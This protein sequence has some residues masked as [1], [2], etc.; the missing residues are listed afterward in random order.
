MLLCKVQRIQNILFQMIPEKRSI[1]ARYDI[2]YGICSQ[3]HRQ[4]RNKNTAVYRRRSEICNSRVKDLL[5]KM[6]QSE[7][8]L[9]SMFFDHLIVLNKLLSGC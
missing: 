4:K 2:A 7:L 6:M 8:V 1:A 3:L 5:G 9:M